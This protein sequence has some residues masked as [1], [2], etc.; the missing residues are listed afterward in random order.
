[1]GTNRYVH[2][3]FVLTGLLSAFLLAVLFEAVARWF[4]DDLRMWAGLLETTWYAI[5]IAA[6]GTFIAWRNEGVFTW[7]T[8]VAAELNK[9]TWPTREETRASTIVVMIITVIF[10]GILGLFDMVFSYLTD[11]LQAV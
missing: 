3:A 4:V 2:L 6:G 10:A 11:L 5:P 9:V 7:A 8:E 1:M